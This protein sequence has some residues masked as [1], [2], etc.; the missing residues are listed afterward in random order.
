MTILLWISIIIGIGLI[1]LETVK[2]QGRIPKRHG[3]DE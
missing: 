2:N 1:G 3:Y